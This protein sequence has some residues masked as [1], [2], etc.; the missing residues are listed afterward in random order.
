MRKNPILLGRRGKPI[1]KKLLHTYIFGGSV[2]VKPGSYHTLLNKF[3]A[4]TTNPKKIL[5]LKFKL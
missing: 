1:H 4:M 2:F 3:G 5:P